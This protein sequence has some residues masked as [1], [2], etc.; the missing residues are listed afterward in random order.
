MSNPPSTT[1]YF[2]SF[3]SASIVIA[4]G[5][6]AHQRPPNF[7]AGMSSSQKPYKSDLISH[8]MDVEALKFGTFVLKS[9]RYETSSFID[10]SNVFP[11]HTGSHRISS[12]RVCCVQDRFY[13]QLP[14]HTPGRS[15][16]LLDRLHSLSLTSSLD[17]LIKESHFL[18]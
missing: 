16:K 5:S 6:F 1:V 18:L 13:Q 12:T 9:G 4:T 15:M 2:V 7:A 10:Y 3:I 11:S 8:S 14:A 17:L